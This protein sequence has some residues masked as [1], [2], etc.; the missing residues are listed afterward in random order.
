MLEDFI[1]APEVGNTSVYKDS[2]NSFF[3]YE[4]IVRNISYSSVTQNYFQVT[5]P[6]CSKFGCCAFKCLSPKEKK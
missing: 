3:S 2:Y 1:Q 6:Y 5:P 4:W